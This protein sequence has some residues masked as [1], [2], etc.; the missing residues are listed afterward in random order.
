MRIPA[1]DVSISLEKSEHSSILNILPALIDEIEQCHGARVL[2][3]V[4][5]A[6]QTLLLRL[7]RKS[8]D[9]LKLHTGQSIFVQIKTVALLND[10]TSI[11]SD[12]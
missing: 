8:V 10:H 2:I 5:L 6:Q 1:R 11:N 3:R 7:T 4:K 9:R 12:H